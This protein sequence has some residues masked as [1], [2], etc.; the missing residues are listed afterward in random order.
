MNRRQFSRAIAGAALGAAVLPSP[1]T[2]RAEEDQPSLPFKLSV[3]I[4]TLGGKLSLQQRLETVAQAGY[5][6]V[7]LT[8]DFLKWSPED[9]RKF[10]SLKRSLG[11]GIDATGG[12]NGGVGDPERRDDLL[13]QL[14][15]LVTYCDRLQCWTFIILS[16]N[17]IPTLSGQQQHDACIETLK[18]MGDI[19]AQQN[20]TVL[21]ENIDPEEN[22]K[23]YLTSAAEGFEIIRKVDHP[24][25]KFLYDLYHEQIAEGNLI[26][27]LEKNIGYLGLIHIADVPGRH[28]PG[29]GE[30]N[31]ASVFRKLAELKYNKYAAMEF[32]P[33]D[34]PVAS[35]RGARE[36]VDR[37]VN[38]SR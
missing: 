9:F 11:V 33:T 26:E 14:K 25:V 15:Y 18:R 27:K 36:Y 37:A 29:T 30:I 8:G 10:D 19:A 2:L 5:H 28:E 32:L 4:W 22:P 21:L 1:S 7:E 31:Y 13:A 12:F 6:S 16:G 35:L 23:Y 24:N 20:V 17:R 38:A 3:M 34:D